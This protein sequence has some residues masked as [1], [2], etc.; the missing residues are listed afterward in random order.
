M[1]AKESHTVVA[2]STSTGT[3]PEGVTALKSVLPDGTKRSVKG[4]RS[5]VSTTHGGEATT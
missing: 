3:R 4:N 1:M 2:P 5:S